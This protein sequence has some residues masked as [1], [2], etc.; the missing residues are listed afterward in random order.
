MTVA[1]VAVS[2]VA[3]RRTKELDRAESART[4]VTPI[5]PTHFVE[6]HG[7]DEQ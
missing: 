2:S 6:K 4:C 5:K 1:P 3:E 7:T